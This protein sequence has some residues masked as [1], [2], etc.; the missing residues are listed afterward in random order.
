MASAFVKGCSATAASAAT[1]TT[2]AHGESSGNVS[3][4]ETGRGNAGPAVARASVGETTPAHG[5]VSD[6]VRG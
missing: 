3:P 4:A 6:E 5:P 1:S 2:G